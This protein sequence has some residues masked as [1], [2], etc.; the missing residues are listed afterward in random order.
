[1]KTILVTGAAG[2]IGSHL[3]EELLKNESNQVIGLDAYI[4]LTTPV[5]IKERNVAEL[6]K[7]PRFTFHAADLMTAAW[8]ELLPGVDVIYH[9]AGMPGVR[10][11][12]GSDF[13]HYANYN[14]VATQR[15]LEGCRAYPINRLIFASTSSVYGEKKGKVD[16][17]AIP[18]P[19]SPY[20]ITK[21][22]CEHLCRVYGED[23]GIPI[24]IMRFFTVYGP[25]QRPDMAFHRFIKQ[26]LDGKPITLYGDGS[27]SRDF[28]YIEDCVRAVAAAASAKGIVGQ[29]IN[30]GGKERASVNECIAILEELLQ[31]KARVES[32]GAPVGEPKSTWADISK[33]EHL[34]GYSPTMD[35]KS[36]LA[37]EI[38]YVRQLY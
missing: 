23:H 20:G 15:L 12:W 31:K 34:L 36:G 32:A 30:I 2:F 16:E 7:H 11:S 22:T 10:S 21:L 27:Q 1:M 8:D 18:E 19:L 13:V 26:M 5:W 17:S 37:R 29:T 24:V 6:L 35:L 3:C 14:I 25:R 33:A 38:A 9:L 28:T 4:D